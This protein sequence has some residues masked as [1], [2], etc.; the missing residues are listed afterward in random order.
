MLLDI[1]IWEFGGSKDWVRGRHDETQAAA[2]DGGL[3][4]NIW[5]KWRYTFLGEK[6]YNLEAF[7]SARELIQ[8]ETIEMSAF[9]AMERNASNRWRLSSV[10]CETSI[11]QVCR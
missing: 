10:L 7:D 3:R 9:S 1:E 11:T 2:V 5:Q 6:E 4:L 8:L